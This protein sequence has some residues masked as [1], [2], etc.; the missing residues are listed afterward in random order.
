MAA[1]LQTYKNSQDAVQ[2]E[3]ESD[4]T[5]LRT[6]VSACGGGG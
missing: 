3:L 4:L 1:W 6:E 5:Y 2:A